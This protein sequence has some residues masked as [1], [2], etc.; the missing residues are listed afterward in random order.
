VKQLS[1]L[2]LCTNNAELFVV[3]ENKWFTLVGE[4]HCQ[5]IVTVWAM[6]FQALKIVVSISFLKF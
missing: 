2:Q 5:I 4:G 6:D 3:G 1:L